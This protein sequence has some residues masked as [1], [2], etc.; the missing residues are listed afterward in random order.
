MKLPIFVICASALVVS[1]ASAVPLCTA[2]AGTWCEAAV[3]DAGAF[4]INSQA[5][6]G[7]GALNS[8]I[9]NIGNGTAG[10]DVY[11]IL[12]QNTSQF[13]ATFGAYTANGVS[14]ESNAAIY[15]YDAQ[16]HGVE[17][18]LEGTSLTGFNGAA[19]LYYIGITPDGNAPE[20]SVNGNK[21]A[22]FSAFSSGQ[23]SL[24]VAGAGVLDAYS[25]AGC[26]ANC[27]GA[28]DITLSGAQYSNAPEPASLALLGTALTSL[29]F[30]YRFKRSKSL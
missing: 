4:P 5:T 8:I 19:G 18:A 13:A 17:A 21:F 30:L 20:Y 29:S 14:G 25:G 2:S 22:I 10:S 7:T 9:G 23:V 3:G 1:S 16:G 11:S 15:L 26:G 28:Y 27:Q 24:P 6:M 12:I